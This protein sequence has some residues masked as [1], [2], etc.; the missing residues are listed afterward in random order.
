MIIG[1]HL[2]RRLYL[3]LKL[4]IIHYPL[5]IMKDLIIIG[6]GPAGISAAYEAQK[7]NL[8]YLV[9]EKKSHRQYDLSVSG[10]ADGFFHRQR[11]GIAAEHAFS[12]AGKA[13]AGRITVL[14]HAV[15]AGK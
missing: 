5:S 1:R 15:C 13:D 10:R 12:G 2:Q 9:L 8:N 3:V 14:L 6:A 4:S 11:I 7:S